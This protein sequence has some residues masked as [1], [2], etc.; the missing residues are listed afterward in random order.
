MM[1]IYKKDSVIYVSI[2]S[3]FYRLDNPNWESNTLCHVDACGVDSLS[4]EQL[5]ALKLLLS[6]L[7]TRHMARAMS[8]TE[9][10]AGL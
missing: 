9:T 1:I 7:A 8:I 3:R 2:D 10:L 6:N 5:R 4:P